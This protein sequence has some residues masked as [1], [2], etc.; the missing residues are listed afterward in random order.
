MSKFE[1]EIHIFMLMV[2]FFGHLD[3]IEKIY[4]TVALYLYTENKLS[5]LKPNTLRSFPQEQTLCLHC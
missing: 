4:K 1:E 5:N 2:N 3:R